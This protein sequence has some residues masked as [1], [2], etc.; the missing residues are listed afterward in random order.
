MKARELLHQIN[1]ARQMLQNAADE[2]GKPDANLKV[3]FSNVSRAREL[4]LEAEFN[5]SNEMERRKDE[6]VQSEINAS[7][8]ML[9]SLGMKL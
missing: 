4:I 5:C 8:A 6:K 7:L 9:E 3:I 1:N 2:C